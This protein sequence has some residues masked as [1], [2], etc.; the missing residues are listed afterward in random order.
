MEP[1]KIVAE[2]VKKFLQIESEI[3]IP[4]EKLTKKQAEQVFRE[5]RVVNHTE[6]GVTI[7]SIETVNK[8][9]RHK[10]FDIST[11]IRFIPKLY[12]NS[13]LIESQTEKEFEDRIHKKHINILFW[14]NTLNKFKIRNEKTEEFDEYVIRFTIEEEK[15][16]KNR[17]KFYIQVLYPKF[18]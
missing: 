18:I 6:L 17:N 15:V 2:R 7:L 4:H 3:I 12:E 14:H 5:N 10:G 16:G 11:I 8:I 9:L 1:E 13:M